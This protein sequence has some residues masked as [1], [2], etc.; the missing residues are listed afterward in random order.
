MNYQQERRFS[1][2]PAALA[3]L[4]TVATLTLGVVLPAEVGA[5]SAESG[6]LA[7]AHGT[8]GAKLPSVNYQVDVVA[9]REVAANQIHVQE[10]ARRAG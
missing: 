8:T 10:T 1:P 7:R 4:A 3:V 9:V 5:A 2:I 6:V